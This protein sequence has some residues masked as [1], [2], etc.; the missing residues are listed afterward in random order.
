MA[1]VTVEDCL[2]NV[3]NRFEL[4]ILASKR[5]RQL[6]HGKDPLVD[7][8][9]DKASVVALREIAAGYTDFDKQ[10]F[11]EIEEEAMAATATT[12]TENKEN[13]QETPAEAPVETPVQPGESES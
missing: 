12:S 3:K 11:A 10:S 6:M 7:W 2:K 4:V 5:A 1:R 9:N 13:K 8:D